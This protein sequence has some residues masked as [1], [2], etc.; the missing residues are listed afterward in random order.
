VR[1]DGWVDPLSGQLNRRGS[2]GSW[3]LDFIGT[4]AIA[5]RIRR[6]SVEAIDTPFVELIEGATQDPRGDGVRA[7]KGLIEQLEAMPLLAQ[8]APGIPPVPIE[9]AP[10]PSGAQPAPVLRSDS[11]RRAENSWV[12]VPPAVIRVGALFVLGFVVLCLIATL[13]ARAVRALGRL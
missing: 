1:L 4:G 2:P 11:D 9:S 3:N 6:A 7:G 8:D 10:V 5:G 12:G 13:I